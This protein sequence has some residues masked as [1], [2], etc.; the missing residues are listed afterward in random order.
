MLVGLSNILDIHLKGENKM[1]QKFTI[2]KD[3]D[4]NTLTISEYAVIDRELKKANA[5]SIKTRDF[6]LIGEETYDQKAVLQSI[7]I[8]REAVIGTLRTRNLFPIEPYA[9]EIAET[10]MALYDS[11]DE[12]P[13]DLFFDDVDLLTV[14]EA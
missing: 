4:N 8:G 9:R 1:R 3:G 13:V 10:V 5:P 7:S 14:N 2:S 11:S 12:S 6:S